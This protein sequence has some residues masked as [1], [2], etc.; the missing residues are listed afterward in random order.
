MAHLLRGHVLP[1]TRWIGPDRDLGLRQTSLADDA[2]TRHDL[3]QRQLPCRISASAL[4]PPFYKENPVVSILIAGLTVA[5]LPTRVADL[6]D[7]DFSRGWRKFAP[8]SR[9]PQRD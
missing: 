5:F 9:V 3:P 1:R 8:R 4:D 6:Q 2:P 7:F